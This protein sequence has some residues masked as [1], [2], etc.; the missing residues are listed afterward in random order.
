MLVTLRLA[1]DD[2]TDYFEI[3]GHFDLW[4]GNDIGQGIVTRRL[5]V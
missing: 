5:F 2:V 4:L 3:G 1:G